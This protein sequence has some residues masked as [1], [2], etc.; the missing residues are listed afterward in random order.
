[1]WVDIG[2]FFLIKFAHSFLFFDF[3]F[4]KVIQV[5]ENSK[6]FLTLGSRLV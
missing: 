6:I 2:K 3:T 1:M 5:F 4:A